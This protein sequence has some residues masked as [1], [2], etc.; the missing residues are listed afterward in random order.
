MVEFNSN[1][2]WLQFEAS[3]CI[4]DYLNYKVS[5]IMTDEICDIQNINQLEFDGNQYLDN[6]QN[7]E[8]NNNW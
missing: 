4:G 8:L 2:L 3:G 6:H 5:K 7:E 1:K